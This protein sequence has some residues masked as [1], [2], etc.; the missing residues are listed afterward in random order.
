MLKTTW[1]VAFGM[2]LVLA[3][4]RADAQMINWNDRAFV[5]VNGGYQT[6][7]HD[8]TSTMTFPLYNETATLRAAHKVGSGALLDLGGGWRVWRNA[9]IGIAYSRF[10]DTDDIT[11]DATLPHPVLFD[12]PR[13]VTTTAKD[14][15][16]TESAV[17]IFGLWMLPVSRKMDVAFFLGPTI[18][19]VSQDLVTS[20]E[21]PQ[22]ETPPF[23]ATVRSL[24]KTEVTKTG[25]GVNVGAD[26]SYMVTPQIGGGIFLRYSAASAS[27]SAGGLS[28]Q[29]DLGG[30]Q[31]GGGLRARFK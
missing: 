13:A 8:F 3:V 30:F 15:K 27:L 28:A 31:I 29:T 16:R 20:A 11:V 10:Q 18:F 5:N 24:T 19:N 23:T 26:W 25:V 7:S 4:P 22:P 21:I 17:H 1:L 2:L 14:V 6:Q 12:R 9:A